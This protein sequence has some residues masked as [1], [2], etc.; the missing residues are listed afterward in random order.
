MLTSKQRAY[1]RGLANTINPIIQIG[2]A[3]ITESLIKQVDDT[4]EARELVKITGLENS[5]FDIKELSQELASE[6]NAEVV[7]VIGRKFSLYRK[8]KEPTINLP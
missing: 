8:S 3:S 4:L 1:L 2:K 6:V 5:P 7:Q